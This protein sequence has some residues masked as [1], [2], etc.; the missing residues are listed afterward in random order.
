MQFFGPAGKHYKFIVN[1]QK[2]ISRVYYSYPGIFKN[3]TIFIFIL[4][5]SNILGHT[6]FLLLLVG[7]EGQF[8]EKTICVPVNNC[9]AHYTC[10]SDGSKK[11]LDG[12]DG[13][14]C[15]QLIDNSVADCSFYDCKL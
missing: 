8:C 9:S 7:F 10:N 4:K 2:G 1:L 13:E 11:C 5:T 12:W 14:N 3:G 6:L 15:D